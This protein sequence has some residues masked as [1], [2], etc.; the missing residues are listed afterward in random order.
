MKNF[1][2]RKMSD[3]IISC[4]RE[5]PDD[6]AGIVIGIH[7]FSSSKEG[8]TYR[9]LLERLPQAGLGVICIDL[10][11]HGTEDSLKETLRIPGAVDSIGAAE[12]YVRSEYPGCDIFYF[13]SSFGA[14]LTCLYI[15]GREHT[16]RKAFLRSAAV[17]MPALFCKENPTDKEKQQLRDLETKGYFDTDMD[18]HRPVRIVREMYN[19]LLQNDLFERFDGSLIGEHQILMVHGREDDVIDPAEA[20]RF[21]EKF[22]I[23]IVWFAGEGHSLSN[24]P[25]TPGK[26]VDMAGAFF[27]GQLSKASFKG[28]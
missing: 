2:I 26:V 8:A 14:Y 16:G 13:G 12:S 6:P 3:D 21:A 1:R 4:V 20:E 11:G 17:N 28:N 25:S 22:H 15:S 27:K 10:P 9:L 23:P 18:L 19:D 7:G 24:D 5:I